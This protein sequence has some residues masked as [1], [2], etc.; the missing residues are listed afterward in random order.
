MPSAPAAKTSLGIDIASNFSGDMFAQMRLLLQS[1]RGFENEKLERPPRGLGLRS[2][3]VLELATIGGARAAGLDGV[4][5]SI[6][7]GK[8]AD[9]VV[10]RTDSPHMAAVADPVAA[11]V[12][13]AAASDV[14][15]VLVGGQAAKRDGRLVG[16]D[17]P[18]ISDRLRRSGAQL[19]ERAAAIP[20][21]EIAELLSAVMYAPAH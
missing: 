7:P 8:Q 14:D 6:T 19:R 2:R 5:G 3:D 18:Q 16:V 13:Y 9:L 17:W 4:T 20:S 1:E 11:L 21:G 10:T 15:T 12:L